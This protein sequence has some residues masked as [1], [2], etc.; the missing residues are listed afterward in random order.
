ASSL[1][2]GRRTRSGRGAGAL[3]V[4]T[5]PSLRA[6]HGGT[7]P[8]RLGVPHQLEEPIEGGGELSGFGAAGLREVRL[9]A[10]AS[11]D[12]P[13]HLPHQVAGPQAARGHVLG[14]SD[15]DE[16]L[17][18]LLSTQR[19]DAGLELVAELI[20]EGPIDLGVGGIDPRRNDL[21]A[22]DLLDLAEEIAAS[23]A[24]GRRAEDRLLG[25]LLELLHPLLHRLDARGELARLRLEEGRRT[26]EFLLLLPDMGERA[27]SGD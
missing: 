6:S 15:E 14:R 7:A 8:S 4:M 19:H 5:A 23:R 26:L 9:P 21:H 18:V 16:R 17:A 24:A 20:G 22:V 13:G 25:A 11:A 10:A 3:P 1:S 2:K 27:R 12:L